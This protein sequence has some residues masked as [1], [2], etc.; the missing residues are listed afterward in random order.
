MSTQL[1]STYDPAMPMMEEP[2]RTTTAQPSAASEMPTHSDMD[3]HP[4]IVPFK[5][6][7]IGVAKKTRGTLL[8]K[9][10]LKEH[11]E[12]ILQGEASV[13]D[14]HEPPARTE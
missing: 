11:G 3:G 4:P 2:T 7:V 12:K 1:P 13:Y 6:R 10:E 9:P 8:A 14:V 5:E